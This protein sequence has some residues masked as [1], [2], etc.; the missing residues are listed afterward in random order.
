MPETFDFPYH[1]PEVRYPQSSTTMQFGRGYEFASKPPAPDQVKYLLHFST[2]KFF[3][4]SNGSINYALEPKINMG[5]LLQ[6][7]EA[8]R[9]YEKFE[10]PHPIYGTKSVRFATPLAYKIKEQGCATVEP[11][12]IDLVLQP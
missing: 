8:H 10:Y 3:L 1:V 12:T 2:M 11:F 6:F 5:K 9:L 7:Y 4:N